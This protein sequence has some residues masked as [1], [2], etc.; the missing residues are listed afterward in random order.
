MLDCDVNNPQPS[1]M[2]W[3]PA[4]LAYDARTWRGLKVYAQRQ[5]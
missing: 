2:S 4:K 1:D 3:L 5:L